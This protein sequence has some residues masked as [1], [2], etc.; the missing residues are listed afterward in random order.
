M[1]TILKRLQLIC[2]LANSVEILCQPT[3]VQ[4]VVKIDHPITYNN[5]VCVIPKL[6]NIARSS[7]YHCQFQ[8]IITIY[9][10]HT[11]IFLKKVTCKQKSLAAKRH[12]NNRSLSQR[13]SSVFIAVLPKSCGGQ[14]RRPTMNAIVNEVNNAVF[15]WIKDFCTS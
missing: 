14:S 3:L 12:V 7:N 11:I 5:F 1:V 10:I 8:F 13:A 9:E 6:K 15:W 2:R 4:N